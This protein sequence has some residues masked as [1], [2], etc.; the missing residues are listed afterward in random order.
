MWYAESMKNKDAR[1]QIVSDLKN[2]VFSLSAHALE[3]MAQRDLAAVD[4]IAL[5]DGGAL[6]NPV[7]NIENESWNF[8][9]RGFSEGLFTIACAYED[10]GTLIVTVF[11]E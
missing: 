9:G 1:D 10:D 2:N 11:W 8:T 6:K 5:I 4:I 7:W 3:R